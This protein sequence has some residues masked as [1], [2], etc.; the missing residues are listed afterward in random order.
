MSTAIL[1]TIKDLEH[2]RYLIDLAIQALQRLMPSG[3]PETPAPRPEP[4]SPAPAPQ[5]VGNVILNDSARVLL[6]LEDGPIG[7][8]L[9]AS[10]LDLS[11]YIVKRLMKEMADQHLVHSTGI[12]IA[13]RWHLGAKGSGPKEAESRRR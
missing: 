12:T 10:R 3:E 6:L 13:Q 8:G 1:S 7:T 5:L 9:I 2:Q 11:P 4:L